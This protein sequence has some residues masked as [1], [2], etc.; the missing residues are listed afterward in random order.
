MFMFG[1]HDQIGPSKN[2]NCEIFSLKQ[3]KNTYCDD[4]NICCWRKDNC[5]IYSGNNQYNCDE[6]DSWDNDFDGCD[7]AIDN[8]LAE[9]CFDF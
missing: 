1:C 9:H 2:E 7:G 6:Y 5:V 4:I 3:T 8:V